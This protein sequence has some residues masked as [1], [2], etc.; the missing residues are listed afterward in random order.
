[1]FKYLDSESPEHTRKWLEYHPVLLMLCLDAGR[2]A[3]GERGEAGGLRDGPITRTTR[4]KDPDT[5]AIA[6]ADLRKITQDCQPLD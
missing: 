2:L 1:M 5:L 6:Q 3:L 4:V